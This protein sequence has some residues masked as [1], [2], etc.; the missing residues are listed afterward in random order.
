MSTIFF[1][2]GTH[3]WRGA[4]L[5]IAV[6]QIN[7]LGTWYVNNYTWQHRTYRHD[8]LFLLMNPAP[9][10][11]CHEQKSHPRIKYQLLAVL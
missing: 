2:V 6:S 11:S 10:S 4:S 8:T 5:I 9:E 3:Q 7:R 1:H